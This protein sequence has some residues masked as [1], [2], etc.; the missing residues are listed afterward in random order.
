MGSSVDALE[1]LPRAW[2][3]ERGRF[4]SLLSSA[5]THVPSSKENHK[6]IPGVSGGLS[7]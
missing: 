5:G 6:R 1:R 7:K 4:K 3:K 2:V